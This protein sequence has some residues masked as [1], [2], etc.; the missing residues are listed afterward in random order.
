VGNDDKRFKA[1][2]A[3]AKPSVAHATVRNNPCHALL[4]TEYEG[5]SDDFLRRG[6]YMPINEGSE[7]AQDQWPF[8]K[9]QLGPFGNVLS[10]NFLKIAV[11]S[12]LKLTRILT[13]VGNV[14]HHC[15]LT[16]T[17]KPPINACSCW[18]NQSIAE[19]NLQP[20]CA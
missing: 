10:E 12:F 16:A 11:K 3:K 4:V 8:K 20:G 13:I 15:E 2:K 7:R 9:K 17:G 5:K 19:K 6:S 1:Q 14:P 18:S